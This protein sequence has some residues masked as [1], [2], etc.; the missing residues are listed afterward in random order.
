MKFYKQYTNKGKE[1]EPLKKLKFRSKDNL[2]LHIYI[3]LGE[4][5]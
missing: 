5:S 1:Q 3:N 4:N 2:D